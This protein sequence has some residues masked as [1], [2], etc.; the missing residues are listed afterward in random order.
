MADTGAWQE[1]GGGVD[2]PMQTMVTWFFSWVL[3]MD[4]AARALEIKKSDLTWQKASLGLIVIMSRRWLLNMGLCNPFEC[5][6]INLI[7]LE[8]AN[9]QVNIQRTFQKHWGKKEKIKFLQTSE[10]IPQ[11]NMVWVSKA[12]IQLILKTHHKEHEEFLLEGNLYFFV[13]FLSPFDN[14]FLTGITHN[15]KQ[16]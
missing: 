7:Q 2:N 13:I 11:Q 6:L 9:I 8:M 4:F 12:E 16:K 1:R 14:L 3:V 15:Y 10:M 5:I